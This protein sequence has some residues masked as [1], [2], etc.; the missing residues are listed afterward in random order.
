MRS[1]GGGKRVGMALAV[2]AM[3]LQLVLSY[4][5][6]HLHDLVSQ[7]SGSHLAAPSLL[8]QVG[9]ADS[10]PDGSQPA[11]A[12]DEDGCPI[13]IAMH[14]V[15]NGAQP[16]AP[17]VASPSDFSRP[18]QIAVVQFDCIARRCAS[19]QTRAPPLA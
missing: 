8:S 4:G 10:A 2:V 14:M 15:A 5:H 12:P 1:W 13:C 7:P 9:H 18:P 11:N 16:V 6:L 19:F 17:Q 3:L